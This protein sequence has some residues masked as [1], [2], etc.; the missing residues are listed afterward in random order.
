MSYTIPSLVSWLAGVS[1]MTG[2]VV[3]DVC[4]AVVQC[5]PYV[6]VFVTE[7]S[8]D[9]VVVQTVIQIEV[10]EAMSFAVDGVYAV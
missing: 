10:P 4:D 9:C 1:S 7:Q 6:V 8:Q 5:C 2:G 3:V